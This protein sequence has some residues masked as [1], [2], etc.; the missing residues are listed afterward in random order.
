MLGA[1]AANLA[2]LLDVDLVLLGGRTVAAAPE[3]FV[4]GVGAV[5]A[6]RARR[7]GATNVPFR[8]G[9]RPAGSAG[10]RR[11]RHNCCSLPCSGGGRLTPGCPEGRPS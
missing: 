8:C 6:A 4:R 1:G 3:V 5:L 9:S 10:W 11:A 2:G 7:A